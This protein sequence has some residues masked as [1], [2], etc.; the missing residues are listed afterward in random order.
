MIESIER[1]LETEQASD[2][3]IRIREELRA[4]LRNGG[5]PAMDRFRRTHP[6]RYARRLLHL[7]PA[8]RY[9]IVVMTWAGGQATPIHDHAGMWCVEG[10]VEGEL[11]V[12][13]YRLLEARGDQYQFEPDQVVHAATGSTGS[14][15]PPHEYH[16]LANLRADTA[17]T[18]HVYGGEIRQ[19]YSFQ[20]QQGG[21]Y[22]RELRTLSYDD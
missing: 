3:P 4:V 16:R 14:L 2:I 6:D 1:L 20:P 8:G 11:E 22:R 19:C 17:V 5:L 18:V 15:I 21:W 13:Q 12:T 7:D 9:S 10:V